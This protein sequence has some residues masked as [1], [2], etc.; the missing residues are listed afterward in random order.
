VVANPRLWW[1]HTVGPQN[2]Y[3]L[4]LSFEIDGKVSDTRKTRFGIREISSWMNEFDTLRTKVFQVNGKNIVIRGGGYVEDLMLRPSNERVDADIHYLKFMNMNALRMEAPR[5]SDYLFERCDEEGILIMVGWCCGVPFESWKNWTPHTADIAEKSWHDQVIN[6]RAHPSVFTWLYGSDNFPPEDIELRYIN[7]LKQYDGTRPYSSSATQ[8]PS[9]IAGYTGLF[10]GPWP[11][12]YGYLPPNYWYS[13]LEFNTECG[14][15]GE[16]LP[17]IETIKRVMPEKD[18]WPVGPGWD[19]R[20]RKDFYPFARKALESRYGKPVSL[21][22]YCMKSQIL[23]MEAVKAMF[24]AF[25]GN[26]YKSSGVIYWMYNS[27][28]PKFYWQLYDYFFMPNGAFYGAK[29]ACEPLHIQYNYKENAVQ[30]VNCYYQDFKDLKVAA[31]A[32]DFQ[33]KE[34]FSKEIATGMK[35]DESKILFKLDLPEELTNVYFVKLSLKDEAGK[36]ISSN[37][38]WLSAKGV[39]NAD[40]T[41]LAKLP[42]VDVTAKLNPLL[43]ENGKLKLAVEFTNS[44]TS[45]AFAMNPKLLSASTRE[46]VLPIF[47]Q[48]NYF[49]LLPGEKRTVEVQLDAS[50]VKEGK[51]LFKL[52]GWNLRSTQ[53]QE[54][55]VP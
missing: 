14:P 42:P 22:E 31:K 12:V 6:L 13:K 53:E 24:E 48:D 10:M 41:D 50:L 8:E 15:N 39:E 3:D 26:K 2:L 40:F 1:P 30:L 28:W 17:P 32:F 49:S 16:Q 5:G 38:Y 51:L 35:A 47:W 7:V 34:I 21:E 33:M 19:L 23:Q 36:E 37:F 46:P 4:N 29:K 54:L 11:Q 44:S 45:L 18:L 52:D 55:S 43:K 25:A 20:L 27:A 9:K